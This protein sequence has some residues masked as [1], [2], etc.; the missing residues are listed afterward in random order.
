[1]NETF[2]AGDILF[3]V[4][5]P[6]GYLVAVFDEPDQAQQALDVLVAQGIARDATRLWTGEGALAYHDQ[7]KGNLGIMSQL[8]AK[9]PAS[10]AEQ[11]AL[12]RYLTDARE[13]RAFVTV[14]VVDDDQ[15]ERVRDLLAASGGDAMRYYG[16]WATR[17][18][19]GA[20]ASSGP[21]RAESTVSGNEE[22]MR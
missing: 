10:R 21:P 5:Y 20:R 12:D 3:G 9:L 6:R 11:A 19:G 13:G 4:F 2:T 22:R 1:M 17:E 14:H 7:L 8:A 16:R 15:L 18:L